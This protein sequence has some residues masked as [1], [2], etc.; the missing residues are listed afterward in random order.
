MRNRNKSI[1]EMSFFLSLSLYL[2]GR[3][4]EYTVW[5]ENYGAIFVLLKNI[6]YAPLLIMTIIALIEI[7]IKDG[8]KIRVKR[9][10]ILGLLIFFIYYTVK[11]DINSGFVCFA[12]SL[13]TIKID[14]KKIFKYLY[15]YLLFLLFIGIAGGIGGMNTFLRV[16]G[17]TRVRYAFA[18]DH[19][20]SMQL[21]WMSIVSCRLLIKD[22]IQKKQELFIFLF[23]TCILQLIGDTR[24]A[25]IATAFLLI[26]DYYIK[27][28][29]YKKPLYKKNKW[30]VNILSFSF[31]TLFVFMNG[32]CILY[33]ISRNSFIRMLDVLVT[34]RI[35]MGSRFFLGVCGA[36]IPLLPV[37][38]NV[39]LAAWALESYALDAEYSQWLFTFGL[40]FSLIVLA[41]LFNT[42][43]KIIATNEW[44]LLAIYTAIAFNA[45]IEPCVLSILFNPAIL[46]CVPMMLQPSNKI[47]SFKGEYNETTNCN[48]FS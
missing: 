24:G 27:K 9:L 3:F 35:S 16:H 5:N 33:A 26:F 14:K 6:S 7:E 39:D 37:E 2:L 8:T 21:I 4:L 42:V 1:Y 44:S 19:P 22:R 29:N 17:D 47:S 15:W 36:N 32:C 45:C 41:I 25:F 40:V 30:T 34:G 38:R 48:N 13:C 46:M 28:N 11:Y 43:K 20:Y 18:F 23:V 12:F 31:P 10:F